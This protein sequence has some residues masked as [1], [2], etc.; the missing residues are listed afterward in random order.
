MKRKS[1]RE[2]LRQQM[3]LLIEESKN[4]VPGELSQN[5]QAVAKISK[6][7]F[8]YSCSSLILFCFLGYLVKN[9]S[10][11]LVK[12][13]QAIRILYLGFEDTKWLIDCKYQTCV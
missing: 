3:E 6:E 1:D 4:C 7:L 12:F 13:Q 9:I 10:V 5:S 11:L 2:L 8:K